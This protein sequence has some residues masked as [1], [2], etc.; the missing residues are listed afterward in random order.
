MRSALV[1]FTVLCSS[2]AAEARSWWEKF[3][4][5]AGYRDV[6]GLDRASGRTLAAGFREECAGWGIDLAAFVP[7][8]GFDEGFH[9]LVRL[10]GYRSWK[11]LWIGGGVGYALLDGWTDTSVPHRSGHGL[12]LDAIAGIELASAGFVRSF[13]QLDVSVPTFSARDRYRSSDSTVR[14]IAVELAFGLRF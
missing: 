12:T 6:D 14:P 10:T 13:L 7:V 4:V 11:R 2:A 8:A 5:A 3:Y 9:Q 1:I